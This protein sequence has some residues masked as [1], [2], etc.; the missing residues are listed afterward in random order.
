W[1]SRSVPFFTQ[2]P[3]LETV[4]GFLR[5][6]TSQKIPESNGAAVMEE[7]LFYYLQAEL[8]FVLCLV[9]PVWSISAYC[10]GSVCS[11]SMGRCCCEA[12]P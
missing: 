10:S 1:E 9:R 8:Y 4:K 5:L 3:L 6:H 11:P 7:L 2:K 12:M